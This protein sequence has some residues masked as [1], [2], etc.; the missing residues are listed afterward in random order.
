MAIPFALELLGT[1]STTGR[2]NSADIDSEASVKIAA[3]ILD[4]L[5]IV[6]STSE[7]GQTLGSRLERAVATHLALALT[8]DAPDRPW[9]VYG[10]ARKMA[11]SGFLQYEHLARVKDVIDS[12][13]SGVLRVEVRADYLISPDVTVGIQ[14]AGRN[15]F[16][17]AAISCKWTIRSD[18]VPNIRHE[19]V[20]LT[21]HRRGRQPHIVMVTAEP[22]PTQLAAIG[23]GTG[24][25]DAI[26][27][28]ALR[29]LER[30]V[31]DLDDAEQCSCLS[32]LT[33][34]GRLLDFGDLACVLA[35]Y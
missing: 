22:L 9:V 6:R 13:D 24:E 33:N 35:R 28:I 1:S 14:V 29:E 15:P 23:R 7:T 32:E 25:V 12:D 3:H 34:Q 20:I 11:I 19:G 10:A 21:R 18:E 4:Q 17:H 30:A 2:P 27:H 16:L 8:A 31:V 5:G 26:Y